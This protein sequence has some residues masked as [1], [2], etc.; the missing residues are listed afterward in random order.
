M[1]NV[2]NVH[3]FIERYNSLWIYLSLVIELLT[4]QP[5][6]ILFKLHLSILTHF[7]FFIFIEEVAPNEKIKLF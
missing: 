4:S 2:Y 6:F 3:E 1:C 5:W 7:A